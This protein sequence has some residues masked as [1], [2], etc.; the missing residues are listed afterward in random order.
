MILHGSTPELSDVTS[1]RQSSWLSIANLRI[2]SCFREVERVGRGNYLEPDRRFGHQY[3]D[4]VRETVLAAKRL[5]NSARMKSPSGT[6]FRAAEASGLFYHVR[7]LRERGHVLESW[8]PSSAD[9]AYL[10]LGELITEHDDHVAI[11]EIGW[12]PALP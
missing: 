4:V 9:Q 1:K 7:G 5:E 8:C 10:P 2:V 6:I 12:P 3:L 11:R